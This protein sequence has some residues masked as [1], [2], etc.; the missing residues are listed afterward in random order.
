MRPAV[1]ILVPSVS[2]S[3]SSAERDHDRQTLTKPSILAARSSY[4]LLYYS[5]SSPCLVSHRRIHGPRTPHAHVIAFA[6]ADADA[7]G[8][9]GHR[10]AAC[11]RTRTTTADS[12][13][14]IPPLGPRYLVPSTAYVGT[15]SRVLQSRPA[16]LPP[17][18]PA[19]KAP[20]AGLLPGVCFAQD[21]ARIGSTGDRQA[22]ISKTEPRQA[23]PGEN[24]CATG[25]FF[26]M[27]ISS[28][29]S[30][31]TRLRP[32]QLPAP[33]P[34]LAPTPVFVYQHSQYL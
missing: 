13:R 12:E 29:T 22:A 17:F 2:G 28:W 20:T 23:E 27:M 10:G 26:Q 15:L 24:L 6:F 19:V 16:L 21:V 14:A 31:N 9:K 1:V 33:A 32:A 5:S 4:A 18:K 8:P 7:D 30:G 11:R 25:A 34:A 3:N